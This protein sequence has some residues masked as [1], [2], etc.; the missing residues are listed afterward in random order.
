MK[1]IIF[2][3][4]LL[5]CVGF[6]KAQD[7]DILN[8]SSIQKMAKANLSDELILDVISSS[9]V[10]FNLN[11]D[12]VKILSQ[13]NVSEAIIQAMKIAQEEENKIQQQN[14][15]IASIKPEKPLPEPLLPKPT[16]IIKQQSNF[17]IVTI[18]YVT[19]IKDLVLYFHTEF[20]V[21]AT[22]INT[23]NKQ[24]LDSLQKAKVLNQQILQL[25]L[26]LREKQNSNALTYS[27][28]ILSLKRALTNNRNSLVLLKN[29]MRNNGLKIT[30]ELKKIEQEREKL[31]LSK[32]D[33]ISTQIKAYPINLNIAN[34]STNTS[35]AIQKKDLDLSAQTTDIAEILYWYHNQIYALIDVATVWNA[36]AQTILDEDARLKVELDA[37]Q[38]KLDQAKQNSNKTELSSLK[39]Q[40]ASL[41][42]ERK[43]TSKQIKYD[44]KEFALY[45]KQ[46]K[47]NLA[48]IY[49]QRYA[50]I[51]ENVQ[52]A[53]QE[54]LNF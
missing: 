35:L 1:K 34:T 17:E 37:C 48:L 44:S 24:V 21:L 49:K 4:V 20:D 53:F 15:T 16:N 5:L 47:L 28:E 11:P 22:T 29:G 36:K 23:W 52:Y 39:K 51:I 33:E 25:E 12:S 6:I 19:P 50:N 32:C 43:R 54:K 38:T 7:A 13:N 2:A 46:Y 26:L 27:S 45:V 18:S 40:K 9:E 14:T 31:L 10:N 30:S 8:N 42:K 41:V 3:F